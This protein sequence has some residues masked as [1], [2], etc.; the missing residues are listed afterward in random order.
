MKVPT[1]VL[2]FASEK[3]LAPYL[4]F[5]DY[6]NQY[7]ATNNGAKV[8][9]STVDDKGQPISFAE[10]EALMNAALKREI[11]RVSGV[12]NFTD[13]PLETWVTNPML[14]WATFAVVSAM[15]DMILPESI[16]DTIGVYS[17]VRTI[18]W[19]DTSIFDVE[20]RDLFVVSK[21]GKGQRSTEIHKQYKGTIS[22]VPAMRELTVAVSLYKV[23]A[24]AE[25]L[26]TFVSKVVRSME[27]QLSLDAYNAFAAGMAAL[28]TTATT[29]LQVAGYSQ[30]SLVRL[31][32][33]V[34]AWNQ[35]S[36]AIIMGT[37][38]ALVNVLP[39]DAN[40]RYFLEDEYMKLG[41][42]K[43]AFGY[44]VLALP[45][46]ADLTTPFGTV[47][48]NER[49]WILSP[50]SQKLIKVVLEGST[51]SNTDSTFTNA[52]L[53]Q[54]STMWKSWGVGIATNAIAGIITL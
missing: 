10:K 37:Q 13:F 29:G 33:Q 14:S 39:D 7:R 48:A 26:A 31:C 8:E 16:I 9:F 1:N 42:V 44:D 24:G 51:L 36:K 30:A 3:N 46:V 22:I 53:L 20:P 18:G 4:M 27:T 54:K 43:T 32:Q 5:H 17:D 52:N 38:L 47:L 28:P 49:L 6:Y 35:G 25:S 50:A 2:A 15:I 34:T 12:Q 23:L 11:L 45:Q 41:Y 21:A 40:Y 19:G